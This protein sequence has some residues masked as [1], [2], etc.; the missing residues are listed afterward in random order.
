MVQDDQNILG[1]LIEL[2]QERRS[3]RTSLKALEKWEYAV[4]LA[5]ICS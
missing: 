3:K 1:P 2:V 5:L 4:E